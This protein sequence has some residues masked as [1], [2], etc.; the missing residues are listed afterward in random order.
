MQDTSNFVV[1]GASG[2]I[3]YSLCRRLSEAG[4]RVFVVGR[5][6]E[7][8]QR[9]GEE[10]G[11]PWTTCDATD[12]ESVASCIEAAERELGRI[13]GA[14]HCVGSL[15]LKP[16]HLTSAADWGRTIATNLNSAFYLLRAVIPKMK[17][18]G[19]SL[20]F[21]SSAAARIGL[22]NHEAIAAA[23]AGVQG[24]TIAAAATYG[25]QGIRVNCV[26]PGLV[27][28]PLANRITSNEQSL[29]ASQSMHV[30]GR[31]GRAEDVASAIHWLLDGNQSWVTGQVIGVDGGLGV[32]R[33][34]G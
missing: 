6:Q 29:K 2:G 8:T 25:P 11:A 16:G 17:K 4:H 19:G 20:V 13:D 18:S 34:R 23:K 22:A 26:A 3:G 24:L 21:L 31:I 15:L 28:T 1:L 10:L 32:V 12:A 7:K 5:D 14:A 30:L 27:D 9:L 33:S